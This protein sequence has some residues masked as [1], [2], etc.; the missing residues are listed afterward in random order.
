MSAYF[1]C[2]V[3]ALQKLQQHVGAFFVY[4]YIHTTILAYFL[5]ITALFVAWASPHRLSRKIAL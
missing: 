4:A 5:K 2:R 1:C 3:S